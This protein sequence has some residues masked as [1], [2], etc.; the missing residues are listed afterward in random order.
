MMRTAWE[1]RA[2]ARIQGG[3]EAVVP[4]VEEELKVGK[5][6]VEGGGVRVST[7]VTETPVQEQVHLHEEHVKVDAGPPT[8]RPPRRISPSRKGP[9]RSPSAPKRP[10]SPSRRG[11]SKRS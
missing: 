4:V 9:S 8:G 1:R 5:R 7:H 6:T 11:S 10:S 3:G 2:K